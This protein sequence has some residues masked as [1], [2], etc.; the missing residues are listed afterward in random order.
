MSRSVKRTTPPAAGKTPYMN[1]KAEEFGRRLERLII[2]RGWSNSDLARRVWGMK[3]KKDG[4]EEVANR[5]RVSMY[6]R[7]R[8]VPDPA[9]AKRIAEVLGIPVEELMP[10][11]HLSAVERDN[12]PF[13][14][15]TMPNDMKSAVL[16]VNIVV[17]W[18]VAMKVRE[19]LEPI[20]EQQMRRHG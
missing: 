8:Q 18:E 14:V 20:V 13:S 15:T 16:R 1:I 19:L 12:P 10:D 2:E 4:R 17:P 9:N 7:G 11:I 5:D 3:V 6:I